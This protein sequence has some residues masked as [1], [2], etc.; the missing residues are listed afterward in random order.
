MTGLD[1]ARE[2]ALDAP[3]VAA[4]VTGNGAAAAAD[5][6]A[7]AAAATAAAADGSGAGEVDDTLGAVLEIEHVFVSLTPA[8]LTAVSGCI[9]RM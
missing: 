1:L 6:S 7:A 5:G 3:A 8:V 2:G 9:L 4:A